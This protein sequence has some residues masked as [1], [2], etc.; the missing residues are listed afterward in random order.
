MKLKAPESKRSRHRKQHKRLNS[1]VLDTPLRPVTTQKSIEKPKS[2][3][4]QIPDV[5]KTAATELKL[6]TRR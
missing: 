5:V 6:N 3:K 4:Y 2:K 1:L